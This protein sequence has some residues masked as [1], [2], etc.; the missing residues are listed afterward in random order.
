MLLLILANLIAPF[1]SQREGVHIYCYLAAVLRGGI[2]S[3][4]QDQSDNIAKAVVVEARLDLQILPEGLA[5]VDLTD[6]LLQA[7]EDLWS[8]LG[9]NIGVALRSWVKVWGW[10]ES[11]VE[12]H[13]RLPTQTRVVYRRYNVL[14][15]ACCDEW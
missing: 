3:L 15:S 13:R 14:S 7:L 10:L 2:G 6:G 5:I 4:H 8:R 12:W 1:N 11:F 9:Q